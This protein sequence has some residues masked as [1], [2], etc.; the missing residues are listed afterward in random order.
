[1]NKVNSEAIEGEVIQHAEHHS[2]TSKSDV[3][4]SLK[5][6]D[7]P[8]KQ[9]KFVKEYLNTG[10]ITNSAIKAG[11][12]ELSASSYGSQL[13]KNPKVLA[14]LNNNVEAAERAIVDVMNTESG[15]TKLAAA[16]E[17]MDRT[18]GKAVQRSENV[19]INISVES[20]LGSDKD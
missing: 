5:S 13:L 6:S 16:R 19:N 11:Y 2:R 7:L 18:V 1:M 9:R 14:I 12:S 10:H 17:L 15:M 8:L 3:V 20:M 4:K